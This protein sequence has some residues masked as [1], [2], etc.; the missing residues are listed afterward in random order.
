M[1]SVHAACFSP[2]REE[3][4]LSEGLAQSPSLHGVPGPEGPAQPPGIPLL[5]L[6]Q[7][8]LPISLSNLT[9]CRAACGHKAPSSHSIITLNNVL[10]KSVT[11]NASKKGE[12]INR[13]AGKIISMTVFCLRGK[14]VSCE[15]QREWA[16][17]GLG[18]VLASFE[19]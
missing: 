9:A 15:G 13:A 14:Q 4:V 19:V 2:S 8:P 3:K 5:S 11:F 16:L 18:V 10:C 17:G 12:T 6:P 7:V 1:V